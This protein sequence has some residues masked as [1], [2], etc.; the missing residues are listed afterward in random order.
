[1]T[2]Q[3]QRGPCPACQ[4]EIEV[5]CQEEEMEWDMECPACK[6]KMHVAIIQ[7]WPIIQIYVPPQEIQAP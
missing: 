5:V 3:T 6:V 1:M 2:Q 7:R 4:A